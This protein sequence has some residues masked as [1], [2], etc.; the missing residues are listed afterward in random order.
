MPK[1]LD[2]TLCNAYHTITLFRFHLVEYKCF[3]LYRITE[4]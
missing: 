3:I 1:H 4:Y 2:P